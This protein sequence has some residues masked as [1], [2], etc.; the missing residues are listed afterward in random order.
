DPPA[1]REAPVGDARR[2]FGGWDS[3]SDWGTHGLPWR[4]WGSSWSEEQRRWGPLRL[5]PDA[6][7][8][9][10]GWATEARA[11]PDKKYVP[12]CDGKSVPLR[13]CERRVKIFELNTSIPPQRR[14]GRLLSRLKGGAAAKAG[15][16]DPEALAVPDSA[17]VILCYLHSKCD[18]QETLKVG[19]LVGELVE[20]LARNVSEEALAFEP[21]C[22]TKIRELEKAMGDPLNKHLQARHFLMKLRVDGE[23][24]SHII[25]DAGTELVYTKLWGSAKLRLPRASTPRGMLTLPPSAG[26][27]GGAHRECLNWNRRRPGRAAGRGGGRAVHA[28]RGGQKGDPD[29]AAEDDGEGPEDAEYD[30]EME[31]E[32]DQGEE[33]ADHEGVPEE[34]RAILTDSTAMM[35][36]AKKGRAEAEKARNFYRGGANGGS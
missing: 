6:A 34:L 20:K 13:A 2:Y 19:T 3:W 22:E 27:G 11:D 5:E 17:Q 32:D 23:K 14:G 7:P 10:H 12:E 26:G 35:T 25:A 18:L 24:E 16:F 4:E 33:A 36:L 1:V 28:A 9:Q 15:N 21:R 29:G 31:S 30:E 8:A